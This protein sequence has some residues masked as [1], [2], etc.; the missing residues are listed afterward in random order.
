VALGE[1]G[2]GKTESGIQGKESILKGGLCK[3]KAIL[4]FLTLTPK[5]TKPKKRKKRKGDEFG[6]WGRSYLWAIG[7]NKKGDEAREKFCM[8]GKQRCGRER[9]KI[10]V[11]EK[12]R[13]GE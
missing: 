5:R 6:R 3:K 12:A 13:G 7:R 9:K 4:M 10:L 1:R 8:K 11:P 2:R